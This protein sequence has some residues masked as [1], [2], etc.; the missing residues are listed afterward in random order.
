MNCH[1]KSNSHFFFSL[2]VSLEF[3]PILI[4]K[5]SFSFPRTSESQM[6]KE[7]Q[8]QTTGETL[9]FSFGFGIRKLYADQSKGI[10]HTEWIEIPAKKWKGEARAIDCLWNLLVLLSLCFI[11]V[12][13]V[14]LILM[15]FFFVMMVIIMLWIMVRM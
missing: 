7:I 9:S 4:E 15:F 14:L 12:F 6:Q 5:K 8:H 3:S 13:G 10:Y 1:I 11:V 2:S